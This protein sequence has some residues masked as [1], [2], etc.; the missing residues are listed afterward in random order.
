[1]EVLGKRT[2]INNGIRKLSKT[3]RFSPKNLKTLVIVLQFKAYF[4]GNT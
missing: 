4:T 3:S 2:W 1:M